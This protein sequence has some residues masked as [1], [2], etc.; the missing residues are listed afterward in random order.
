VCH[1]H[2]LAKSLTSVFLVV[3]DSLDRRQDA[4][5]SEM[6]IGNMCPP[7]SAKGGH[8]VDFNDEDTGLLTGLLPMLIAS[9]A[10]S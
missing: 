1:R 8:S 6:P 10:L 2:T 5:P 4:A 3:Y 9:V 7:G